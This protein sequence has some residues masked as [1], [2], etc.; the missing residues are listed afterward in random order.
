[1][2]DL[3]KKHIPLTAEFLAEIA[4]PPEDGSYYLPK[5]DTKK[6]DGEVHSIQPD[7]LHL[8]VSKIAEIPN[9]M[10]AYLPNEESVQQFRNFHNKILRDVHEVDPIGWVPFEIPKEEPVPE[11]DV[12]FDGMSRSAFL[13][14][15][16]ALAQCEDELKEMRHKLEEERILRQ[17]MQHI[18]INIADTIHF[19][20]DERVRMHV[21]NITKRAADPTVGEGFCELLA[22][23]STVQLERPPLPLSAVPDIPIRQNARSG[24]NQESHQSFAPIKPLPAAPNRAPRPNSLGAPI[25]ETKPTPPEKHSRPDGL[26]SPVPPPKP[27]RPEPQ[28]TPVLV[29]SPQPK[30]LGRSRSPGPPPPRRPS[31]SRSDSNPADINRSLSP[32]SQASGPSSPTECSP[33]PVSTNKPRPQETPKAFKSRPVSG[34]DP[35]ILKPL[36]AGRGKPRLSPSGNPPP[37]LGKTTSS[38]H[39]G[40]RGGRPLPRIPS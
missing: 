37:P 22:R 1:M 30:N 35:R 9:K 25:Q 32:R 24:A 39:A 36:P 28:N 29:A 12:D 3:V 10:I 21:E 4:N 20:I 7:Q 34:G 31:H 11:A 8:I 6:P 33:S 18:I 27:S 13:L 17:S 5:A 38:P 16:E 14:M 19:Q 15:R 26:A 2:N 40:A 23:R